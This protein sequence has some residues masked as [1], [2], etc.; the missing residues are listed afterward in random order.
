MKNPGRLSFTSDHGGYHFNHSGSNASEHTIPFLVVG[1][2]VEQGRLPLN[3][4]ILDVVPTICLHHDVEIPNEL[5]GTVRGNQTASIPTSPPALIA[6]FM[7]L[8]AI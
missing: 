5:T 2:D 3:T 6:I 1:R 7:R 4:S 8:M